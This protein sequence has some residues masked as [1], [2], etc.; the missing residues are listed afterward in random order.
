MTFK[1]SLLA[2]SLACLAFGAAAGDFTLSSPDIKAGGHLTSA[3]VFDGFGCTGKNIS[4]AL[5]WQGAPAGTRSYAL[6]VYDP[7]AP[8][9]SG[10]WHWVALN[11]PASV[12][13]LAEGAGTA[14]GAGLPEGVVQVR[15]DFGQPG[16]GGACPPVGDKPHRY[17]FT[18]HALKVPKLDL[19]PNATAALAGYMIHANELGQAGF[20]AYYG[21]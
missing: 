20:T 1:Q 13:G 10:W 5:K 12:Q 9:G 3:Q 16:F 15:T 14:S 19:P 21:R 4:P 6:T 2:S 7:D 11:I 8:T 17:I 18:I